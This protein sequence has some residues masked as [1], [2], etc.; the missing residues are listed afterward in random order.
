M[1]RRYE[2][3]RNEIRKIIAGGPLPPIP[4]GEESVYRRKDDGVGLTISISSISTSVKNFGSRPPHP[5][6]WGVELTTSA[7]EKLSLQVLYP[8]RGRSGDSDNRTTGVVVLADDLQNRKIIAA[9]PIPPAPREERDSGDR[10][11]GVVSMISAQLTRQ[12]G[13]K[14]SAAGPIYPRRI[15]SK[16]LTSHGSENSTA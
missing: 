8:P 7:I 12:V 11:M 1:A 9:G 16:P 2:K 5:P 4:A 15:Q 13:K 3:Q 14:L 6:R 10:T